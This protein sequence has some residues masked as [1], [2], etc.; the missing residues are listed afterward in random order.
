MNINFE[1]YTDNFGGRVILKALPFVVS[2][3]LKVHLPYPQTLWA[4][5]S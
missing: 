3:E 1:R 2:Q 5:R 4:D